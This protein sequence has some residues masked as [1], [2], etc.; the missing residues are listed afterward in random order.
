M[1]L[2]RQIA[3]S[4][5]YSKLLSTIQQQRE[6][7]AVQHAHVESERARLEALIDASDAAI[8]MVSDGRVAYAN[9]PMAE[10][11]GMPREVIVSAPVEKPSVMG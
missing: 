2:G 11:L 1:L 3:T 10:L 9:N 7:L 6:A 5:H 8:L 4:L